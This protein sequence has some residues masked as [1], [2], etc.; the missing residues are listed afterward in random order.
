MLETSDYPNLAR[1]IRVQ[2]LPNEKPATGFS[3]GDYEDVGEHDADGE[4]D[5]WGVVTNKR[6]SM[7][8]ISHTRLTRHAPITDIHFS[9]LLIERNPPSTSSSQ[10][11][12]NTNAAQKAPETLTKRQ[13]QNLQK[14]EKEKAA[15]I[16]AEAERLTALAKHKREA[17]KAKIMEQDGKTSGKT[18]SGG[19]NA[20]MDERGK[21]VW[22]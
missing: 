17:E 7:L 18:A 11:H 13:R 14:R 1:V 5:G 21:L 19:M 22:E 12:A 3:W 4:D 9:I 6:S 16:D 15:K 20:S 10:P 2:P 8:Y